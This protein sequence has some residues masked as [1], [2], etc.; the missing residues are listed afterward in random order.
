MSN[1]ARDIQKEAFLVL[2]GL[3]SQY[4][5]KITVEVLKAWA[6]PIQQEWTSAFTPLVEKGYSVEEIRDAI[7]GNQEWYQRLKK[8]AEAARARKFEVSSSA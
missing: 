7:G 4:S 2:Q 5:R 3:S 1:K 8:E 6:A